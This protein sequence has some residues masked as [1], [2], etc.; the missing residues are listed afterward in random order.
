MPLQHISLCAPSPQKFNIDI[1]YHNKNTHVLRQH[2]SRTDGTSKHQQPHRRLIPR[3]QTKHAMLWDFPCLP[4]VFV[5]CTSG[6]SLTRHSLVMAEQH[7]FYGTAAK[8]SAGLHTTKQKNN[9]PPSPNPRAWCQQQTANSTQQTS[10]PTCKRMLKKS[11]TGS[12]T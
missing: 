7:L 10:A 11:A 5:S 1:L 4:L 6:R 3:L 8:R 12:M 9:V 2:N